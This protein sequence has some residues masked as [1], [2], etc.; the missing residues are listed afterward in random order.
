MN[1]NAIFNPRSIAVVGAS[2][3]PTH[4][5]YGVLKN[6]TEQGYDGEIFP[7]NPNAEEILGRKCFP[8]LSAIGQPVDLAIFTVHTADVKT[9]MEEAVKIGVKAAIVITAG[10]KEIGEVELE[11]E[12][13]RVCH[14]NNIT[15][16]GPNCLGV[17]HPA[18]KMN[19]SFARIMPKVGPVGFFSQSG[20][21]CVAVLDYAE[22]LGIGFSK[23]VSMGNKAQ[24]GEALMIRFMLDDPDTKVI[25]MYLEDITDPHEIIEI[26]RSARMAGNKKPI[27]ALKAGRTSAGAGASASHTGALA[28]ADESF[29][30]FF[31]Q[32]GIIRAEKVSE[33]FDLMK[34]FSFNPPCAGRK[35][36]IV[37]N[38]GGPG[39]LATDEAALSGLSV[40]PLSAEARA[41]LSEFLPKSANTKNP[42]D[43]VGDADALRF[44][45]A[46]EVVAADP[47]TDLSL[48]I[49]TNQTMTQ[50]VETA[51][52]I[53]KIKEQ[54]G[55]PMTACFMGGNSVR[56]GVDILHAGNVPMI[57]Y[58]EEAAHAL[59]RLALYCEYLERPEPKQFIFND[60]NKEAARKILD[61]ARAA[62]KTALPEYEALQL[63]SLY[64][65]PIFPVELAHNREEAVEK[66]ARIG[67][68]LVLKIVS[69][70]ILH[71]S[72]AGGVSLGVIPG[73]AGDAYD[74]LIEAVRLKRP[75]AKI[76]GVLLEEMAERRG[77]EIILGSKRDPALGSVVMVGFGGV[78]AEVFK[79][80]AIG[81]API[82]EDDAR[83][84]I[85]SLKAQKVFEGVRGQEPLD[86]DALVEML[87]RLSLL[88][89]DL[90]EIAEIDIN[91]LK[92]FSKGEGSCVLDARVILI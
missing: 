46:L 63:F 12:L 49:L 4:V 69:P 90:P 89:V 47:D 16:I 25:A 37:T 71:K 23:F 22:N 50:V 72:D 55:K 30:A 19:A 42:V 58:P 86:T 91:P 3:R 21:L 48:A 34:V 65:L 10:Y 79:D 68:K 56:A 88:V 39:V 78:Y 44:E 32:A 54:I 57:E 51:N 33:L 77:F 64:G 1:F 81:L 82:T 52:A 41:K 70:D 76:E 43:V 62:G 85:S 11:T 5:G 28:G 61:D 60:I 45:K 36:R 9:A 38:A 92:V 40:N 24:V 20:A 27:I 29:S 59:S 7:I 8:N 17:I 13:A 15:L 74:A 35:I 66:A 14:E 73:N 31:S 67:K 18:A 75:D 26:I 53:V 6:L 83:R 84:M 2:R 87:G 80:I